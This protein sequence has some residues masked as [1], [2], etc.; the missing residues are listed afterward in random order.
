MIFKFLILSDETEDFKREIRID[1]DATFLDFYNAIME[2][3]GFSEEEMAS[4]FLCDN[5]WH[6]KQEITLMEMATHADEDSYIMEECVLSDFLE[7]ARQKLVFVFDYYNERSLFIELAEV[8][9][10]QHLENPLCTFWL[11]EAPEQ[12]ANKEELRIDTGSIDTGETFYGDESFEMDELD[13][14]GFE[15]LDETPAEPDNNDFY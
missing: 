14:D 12:I 11:G 3:T 13:K 7:D 5:R 4:F 10:G 8:I 1:A 15:G 2:T 6:R 9:P